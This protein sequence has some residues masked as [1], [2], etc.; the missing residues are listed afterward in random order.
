MGTGKT[1][2]RKLVDAA[3]EATPRLPL[4]HS[5]DT[6]LLEEALNKKALQPQECSVFKGE[7]LTYFFYGRP[8]YRPNPNADPSGLG[9][10]FPI[11]LILR[12]SWR[13][14]VK[15]IFPFD[16]GAFKNEMYAAYLHKSMQLEDFGLTPNMTTPG[17]V[18]S[19][20][21]GSPSAYMLGKSELKAEFDAAEFEAHSYSALIGAKDSNSIDS[22]GSSIEVQVGEEIKLRNAVA[23]VALPS[24]FADG[25]TGAK[26]SALKI[27]MLPYRT[28][29]RM[30]P[31]EYTSKLSELCF[32]FCLRQKLISEAAVAVP[33]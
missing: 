9:H 10:H 25:A 5:T 28:Y 13:P 24:M 4:V 30:K 22:R 26:L 3:Q 18:I 21:F 27:E 2:L 32:D 15:R 12:P 6:Y 33:Q 31:G 1:R 16:T 23:A 7:H 20:F 19:I 17:K 11:C 29:E 14:P 8:S